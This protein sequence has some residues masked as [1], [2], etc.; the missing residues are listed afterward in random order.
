MIEKEIKSRIIHKHDTE[1]NW[2]KAVNFIPKKGELIIYDIDTSH[3]YERFKIGDG[4]TLVSALPFAMNLEARIKAVLDAL[5]QKA[6]VQII[7]WE[8]ND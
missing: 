1:E 8:E 3:D 4:I 5:S 7:T 2:L 6:Q